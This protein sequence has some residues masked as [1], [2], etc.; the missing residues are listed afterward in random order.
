MDAKL[1][2]LETA[3]S[4][5]GVDEKAALIGALIRLGQLNREYVI[6]CAKLGHVPSQIAVNL[7]PLDRPLAALHLMLLWFPDSIDPDESANAPSNAELYWVPIQW[8]CLVAMK[9]LRYVGI[10]KNDRLYDDLEALSKEPDYN[11][12]LEACEERA[13]LRLGFEQNMTS[14]YMLY[15]TI[16]ESFGEPTPSR[17]GLRLLSFFNLFAGIDIITPMLG[18]FLPKAA[19]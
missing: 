19:I 17:I 14:R 4:K 15:M 16:R 13:N 1:R 12:Q 5:G 2:Q 6:W 3:A 10:K 8:A 18:F 7:T 9:G 11:A